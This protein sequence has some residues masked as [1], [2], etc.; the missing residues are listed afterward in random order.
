MNILVLTPIYPGPGIGQNYTKVV[1]Y[2]VKEWMNMGENVQVIHLPSFFPKI[3]YNIP[4]FAQDFLFKKLGLEFPKARIC[5]KDT[6]EV[7]N[8]PVYRVPLYKL[9]PWS[10]VSESSRIEAVKNIIAYLSKKK[11]KP[12]LIIAHW[13]DPQLYF[14]DALKKRYNC[15]ASMV[16]HDRP[17]KYAKYINAPDVWGY[18]KVSTPKEFEKLFPSVKFSFR[19]KSGIPSYYLDNTPKRDWESIRNFIYVGTLIERKYADIVL[20]SLMN[21]NLENFMFNIIGEGPLHEKINGIIKNNGLTNTV[22]LLGRIDRSAII[23][24]LD[25]S[26]VFVMISSKEVFGLVYIE[27]MARGCIVIASKNEGMEGII[28]HGENGFL[29]TAGNDQELTDMINHIDKMSA[30]ERERISK[31]AIETAREM[32]DY[33]VAYEYL[34]MVKSAVFK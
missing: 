20:L 28:N 2:F 23:S 9:S 31:K 14:I 16:V 29:V 26:D 18:R 30:K 7:E 22:N 4:K 33:K 8:V 19:C 32:T 11:F 21:S 34:S 12:D 5:K 1:H 17:F 24:H 3:L 15:K 10:V 13:F 25:K 27:A 6:F